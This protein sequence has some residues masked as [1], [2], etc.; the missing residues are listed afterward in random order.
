MKLELL[1]TDPM[2]EIEQM[3]KDPDDV[4]NRWAL[5]IKK[6]TDRGIDYKAALSMLVSPDVIAALTKSEEE[7]EA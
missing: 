3:G 4:L 6:C 5:W 7:K 2:T 1:L